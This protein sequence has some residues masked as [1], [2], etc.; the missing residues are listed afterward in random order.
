MFKDSS[1]EASILEIWRY[2]YHHFPDVLRIETPFWPSYRRERIASGSLNSYNIQWNVLLPQHRMYL[3]ESIQMLYEGSKGDKDPSPVEAAYYQHLT[4]LAYEQYVS[5]YSLDVQQNTLLDDLLLKFT[6][7]LSGNGIVLDIGC[8]PGHDLAK[9]ETHAKCAIGIDI[10]LPMLRFARNIS[11]APVVQMDM[12]ALGFMENS[13]EG[14]WCAA[15]LLHLYRKE[16][17]DTLRGFWRV[18]QP[19][20]ILFISVKQGTGT[21]LIRRS[22]TGKL[23]RLFTYFTKQEIA[24]YLQEV[25]FQVGEI[26]RNLVYRDEIGWNV[27]LNVIAFKKC[28]ER[29]E[30]NV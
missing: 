15:S 10:A 25:G 4:K 8:G 14:I 20:G 5:E 2:F 23:P 9:I 30:S 21:E 27:W 1:S 28:V 7:L 19:K 29:E 17:P 16:V 18:L 26:T 24:N 6:S 3:Q 13:V 11:S 12:R 22:K